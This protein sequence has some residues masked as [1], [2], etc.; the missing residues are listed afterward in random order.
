MMASVAGKGV[1]GPV[2]GD[3]VGIR[4]LDNHRAGHK[5]SEARPRRSLKPEVHKA[6]QP[7]QPHGLI[8]ARQQDC[9]LEWWEWA[10]KLNAVKLG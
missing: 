4:G 6:V 7:R 3:L 9:G 8:K 10:K 1:K 5:N 2:A